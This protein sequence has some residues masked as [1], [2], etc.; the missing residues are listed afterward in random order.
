MADMLSIVKCWGA[1]NRDSSSFEPQINGSGTPRLV[2]G[3]LGDRE[4]RNKVC[5]VRGPSV[6]E[7]VHFLA[8]VG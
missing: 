5:Q 6:W 2:R 4:F 7:I 3:M 1:V 8:P